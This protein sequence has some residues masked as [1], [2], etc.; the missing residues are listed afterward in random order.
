VDVVVDPGY[1]RR[2][3]TSPA[4]AAG[5][6]ARLYAPTWRVI[7]GLGVVVSRASLPLLLALVVLAN[8]PPIGP[9]VLAQ[10]VVL[11]A[12][13]PELAAQLI[14]R[15]CAAQVEIGDADLM[16]RRTDLL[17]EIPLRAITGLQ[18]WRLPVPGSGLVLRMRSGRRLRD[19]IETDDPVPLLD[20]LAAAGVAAAHSARQH[21]SVVYA[22]AAAAMPAWRWYHYA[23]KFVVFGLAPT[24]VFFNAH[25]YIAYGGT[26]G[27]YY[28]LGLGPYLRTFL[29]Y[30]VTLAMYLILYAGVWRAVA[31]S[32]ALWAAWLAPARALQARR[33]AEISCQVLYYAGVPALVAVRFL[34]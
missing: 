8:D 23:W 20:A 26:L 28:L 3:M 19:A 16:V 32:A 34:S 30:W 15:R 29:V 5:F 1:A 12:L 27:Q 11:C 6:P 2:R 9:I 10:L 22:H 4:A 7:G 33:I 24:A 17:M 25:Q 21:P 13:L 18:P 14:R 31:E